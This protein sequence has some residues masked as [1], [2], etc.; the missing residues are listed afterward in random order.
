MRPILALA[1]PI[2]AVLA[3]IAAAP[4]FAADAPRRNVVIFVADGLRSQ[5]VNDQ[6]APELAA[7]RRDGVDFANS[8]SLYPTVTTPNASAIATGHG[9]GDT[10][11]FSNNLYLGDPLG[12]P[13][14]SLVTPVED[15]ASIRLMN[16]RYGGNY[17]NETSFLAAAR[18]AGYQTAVVG[19][20]GPAAVQDVTALSTDSSIIIDDNAG[21]PSN[22][23]PDGAPLPDAVKAAIKAAG[24]APAAPDR[25]LNSDP[26]AYNMPGVQVANTVQQD[27]LTAVTT[28]ALLPMFK[29]SGKPFVIVVWSRDPDG[30][31]H[32]EGDSL[33]KLEPG[34]NG[35]TSM[36]AIRNASADLGRL[37]AALHDLGLEDNTDVFV[38][39][40]HGFSTISRQSQTSG[41]AKLSYRDTMPGF[42][43]PGFLAIDLAKALN[44][45]LN[46]ANGLPVALA[47]G[48][49]PKRSSAALGADPAHPEVVVSVNGGTD[50]LYLP[51]GERAAN[52]RKIV[53][54]LTTQ[55]YASAIFV[56]DA[57]G[58]IPGALPTSAVG[59]KG[60]ALTPAPDIVVSFKSWAGTCA[61]P[62]TCGIEVADNDLQQGQGIHGAFS[63]ADTHNFMAAIGP[64]F[65][66]AYKDAA[67]VSNADIAPTLAH[68]IGLDMPAKGSLTGRVATEALAAGAQTPSAAH[69]ETSAAAANGFVTMLKVQEAGGKRYFDAAGSPGRAL[70]F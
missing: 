45:P 56:A 10:G 48:F 3:L 12:F 36:A 41:A 7:V 60:S 2:V 8:H 53:E 22:G 23:Y 13:V 31:Q 40:D 39:A 34:I 33:G 65:R 21:W 59:L 63:R 67:P 1:A 47:D 38:T 4:A 55:D 51:G 25:G 27:W 49:H 57:L 17:L 62:D 46:D 70:G 20:L 26:G 35:P 58:P 9:L 28:K 15:D 44:L 64:D 68:A 6:T 18:A 61:I 19:K 50:M 42:L 5:I 29:D 24:L 54:F 43:P 11:D 52:A 30:T 32:N 66:R 37:R 16:Q 14:N 69:V